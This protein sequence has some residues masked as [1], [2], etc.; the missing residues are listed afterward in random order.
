[1]IRHGGLLRSFS[2]SRPIR[3]S[4]HFQGIYPQTC[5]DGRRLSWVLLCNLMLKLR[6]ISRSSAI[7]GSDSPRCNSIYSPERPNANTSYCR[8]FKATTAYTNARTDAGTAL[9]LLLSGGTGVHHWQSTRRL[10]PDTRR[11]QLPFD[12]CCSLVL[13]CNAV[14]IIQQTEHI[15]NDSPQMGAEVL[16]LAIIPVPR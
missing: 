11:L 9:A 14:H 10:W 16:L 15:P 5:P 13:P 2:F 1:M 6:C 8:L 4:G 7:L 3:G 12:N